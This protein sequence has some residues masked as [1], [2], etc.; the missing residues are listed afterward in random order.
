MI[1]ESLDLYCGALSQ[2]INYNKSNI[3]FSVSTPFAMRD[4]V[5][6]FLGIQLSNDLGKY[7]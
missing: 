3:M 2:A 4:Y 1:K 7:L 5:A 6:T